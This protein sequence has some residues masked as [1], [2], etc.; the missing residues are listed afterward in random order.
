MK[1]FAVAVC[2]VLSLAQGLAA[3]A[4]RSVTMFVA[5]TGKPTARDIERKLDALATGGVDSFMLYPTSGLGYEYLGK[6][7]FEATRAFASG[8]RKR[9]SSPGSGRAR[10]AG[11]DGASMSDDPRLGSPASA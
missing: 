7:F 11:S 5:F 2:G 3:H 4:E 10:A 8:A 9:R 6:E 1:G